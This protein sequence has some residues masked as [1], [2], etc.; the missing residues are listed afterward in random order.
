MRSILYCY[1]L[2][3]SE[4][5]A[6]YNFQAAIISHMKLLLTQVVWYNICIPHIY[7]HTCELIT[8]LVH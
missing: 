6:I 3:S 2:H 5:V 7:K 8:V 1:L 4:S